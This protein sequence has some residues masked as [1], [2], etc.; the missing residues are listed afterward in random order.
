MNTRSI[1]LINYTI[2][3]SV[4]SYFSPKPKSLQLE[5]IIYVSILIIDPKN[6][7]NVISERLIPNNVS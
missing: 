3:K 1:P 4:S 5:P 7:A 6:L 2:W